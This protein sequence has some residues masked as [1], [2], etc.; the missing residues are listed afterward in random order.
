[1]LA[2]CN[3]AESGAIHIFHFNDKRSKSNYRGVSLVLDFDENSTSE[4]KQEG[5][6]DFLIKKNK[7][8][9]TQ[10]KFRVDSTNKNRPLLSKTSTE[11]YYIQLAQLYD[12]TT[13]LFYNIMEGRLKIY[14]LLE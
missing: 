6:I 7:V 13:L 3:T 8:S 1:M 14:T 5:P 9:N 12:K 4:T 2:C 10:Q 11:Q